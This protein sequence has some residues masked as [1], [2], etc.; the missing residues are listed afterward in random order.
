MIYSKI[1][2][3]NAD[4]YTPIEIYLSLRN[5][6]RKTCLL[7]SNEYHARNNSKSFIGLNPLIELKLNDFQLEIILGNSQETRS[8]NQDLS[9][10]DQLQEL[11]KTFEF[12]EPEINGNGFFGRFGFEF[13]LLTE[14]HISKIESDLD[15]P[16]VHLFLFETIV[17]IDHFTS[18]G[19]VISNSFTN[20]FDLKIMNQV[21][22]RKPF[23]E[24]PFEIIGNEKC[25]FSD[26][27]FAVI[28]EQAIDSC[29]KGNV[30]QLVV[31][32]RFQQTFFGDD[33]QVYRQLRRL[34]PSPYL[35]YFD[36]E[37]YRLFG[38]SPEAQIV[39]RNGKAEIHPIA[40]TVSK[41]GDS[42]IDN[43]KIEFLINDIKEN[44]EHTM[45]VDLA[46]N[47]LSKDCENVKV[48]IYKEVQHFSHVVHLVSKV[49]GQL[50]NVNSF[51][52]FNNSFP[53]GTLSGTPKPKALELISKYEKTTRD[54]YGGAVGLIG[55][56]G[57]LNL[58][59]VIRSVL[60]KNNILNYRA[61]AGVVIN[62]IV[63]SEVNEVHHKLK[64]VRTA[65][66][67]ANQQ[68]EVP[69]SFYLNLKQSKV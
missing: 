47:D 67:K 2:P 27:E 37:N 11:L 39:V 49:T 8:L 31:S 26:Q 45:L 14:K 43:K 38:S 15:L 34:N 17:V 23:T 24:L 32:N 1:T 28:V 5:H 13:S 48:E 62:S 64:A 18:N 25:D 65:I 10:S 7:E 66:L 44:A 59:I 63:E 68:F 55:S 58:A 3:F 29:K 57:D 41:S 60:S 12:N 46:R 53:A 50:S 42:L 54:F 35:F 22:Q 16:D 56:N 30:F 33:F 69:P 6:F 40:G 36:F 19:Y 9:V 4:V 51:S 21:L 61:G 20:E 52:V